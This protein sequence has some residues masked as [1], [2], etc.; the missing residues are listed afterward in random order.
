MNTRFH[1]FLSGILLTGLICLTAGCAAQEEGGG[2]FGG[3]GGG[4]N[5]GFGN[6]AFQLPEADEVITAPFSI[7]AAA[8]GIAFAVFHLDGTQV[9]V[10]S[11][12]PFV[13]E[14]DPL[15]LSKGE[16]RVGVRVIHTTGDERA[17][18]VTIMVV[19]PRP[20]LADIM[21][22]IDGLGPGEWYEIPETPMRDVDWGA[23]HIGNRRGDIQSIIGGGSGGAYDTK[24]DRL[25]VWG[26][27]GTST[28][29]DVYA[30]DLNQAAWVRLTDPSPFADGAD[31]N[32]FGVMTHPDGAPVSR[33]SF[34]NVDYIPAPVDRLYVGGGHFATETET[35]SYLFDFETNT[36]A[37]GPDITK[38]TVGGHAAVDGNNIVWQ[39]GI[40][41]P[42]GSVLSR[43]DVVAHTSSDHA[44]YQSFYNQGATSD[45]DPT[46]NILVAVGDGKTRVWDLDNPDDA[47][48]VWNTTGDP[49]VEDNFGPGAVYDPVSDRMVCWAGGKDVYALDLD[50]KTWTKLAGQGDV[51][52]GPA[53]AI[54]GRWRYVPSKD[55]F[56]VVTNASRNVYVYRLGLLP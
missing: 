39:H 20:P 29:N 42:P 56:I 44:A 24:R 10:V 11:A 53:S 36:W 33:H 2:L 34:D 31:T 23:D 16:H 21:A 13:L 46:R 3:G 19:R 49:E 35:K 30:F 12:P 32:T 8:D 6:V 14:V 18:S 22:A 50:T 1:Q 37:I 48:V 26:G 45:I 47:S 17:A 38:P 7:S 25:V 55:I 41:W 43:V 51:D 40:G 52:P 27:G 9:A 15:A 5:L 4:G 54:L 28:R